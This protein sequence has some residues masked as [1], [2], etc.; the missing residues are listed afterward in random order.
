VAKSGYIFVNSYGKG[1]FNSSE[2]GIALF[3]LIVSVYLSVIR[4]LKKY[5]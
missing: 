5:L 2:Q 4:T 1:C 3:G